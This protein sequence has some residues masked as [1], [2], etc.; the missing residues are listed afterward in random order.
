MPRIVATLSLVALCLFAAAAGAA[1]GAATGAAE[2]TLGRFLVAAPSMPDPRFART[3][4]YMCVHND[5]GAFGL[6]VNR[7]M[8]TAPGRAI[9]EQLGVEA[10][11]G[12][13]PVAMHWGGPVA[14]RRGFVLHTAEYESD[15]TVPVAGGV[16]FSVDSAAVADLLSGAGPERAIFAFGYAGWSP[17]QLERELSRD[18]WLVVPADRDFLFDRDPE[19]MWR[20]A[21]DRLEIDL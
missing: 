13:Q 15:S 3:V 21:L 6:V 20:D 4:I 10:P 14:P 1:A 9:A 7:R 12:Q 17:G 8:G 11:G 19:T 2:S 5:K 16:A 18:D